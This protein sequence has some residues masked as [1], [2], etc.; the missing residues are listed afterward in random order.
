MGTILVLFTCLL[1][2]IFLLKKDELLNVI[3]Y[4]EKIMLLNSL[5][6]KSLGETLKKKKY[7]VW[8][9]SALWNTIKTTWTANID[10]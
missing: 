4:F 9:G 2:F 5:G 1:H 6:A 10:R 3:M 8:V 7:E